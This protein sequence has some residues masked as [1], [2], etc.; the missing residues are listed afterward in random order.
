[1]SALPLWTSGIGPHPASLKQGWGRV[2]KR[3]TRQDQPSPRQHD[4][5]ATWP[6]PPPKLAERVL[7]P[8]ERAAPDWRVHAVA[9]CGRTKWRR[10]QA[11]TVREAKAVWTGELA[12]EALLTR[13][14]P[15]PAGISRFAGT[16]LRHFAARAFAR[17]SQSGLPSRTRQC[18][19][20][21]AAVAEKRGGGVAGRAGLQRHQRCAGHGAQRPV[22][23]DWTVQQ[24]SPPAAGGRGR[25]RCRPARGRGYDFPAR[26]TPAL[27]TSHPVTTSPGGPR[28]GRRAAAGP[29]ERKPRGR[30]GPTTPP[31]CRPRAP[32]VWRS[33]R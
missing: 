21:A 27:A 20:D 14:E 4:W 2:C 31:S 28:P 25:G 6:H 23:F 11:L 5:R 3:S 10:A 7:P 16:K 12:L 17:G 29:R 33:H 15:R 13:P 30:S 22:R 19:P 8:G 24:R 9:L 18:R 1:M 32:A 26:G